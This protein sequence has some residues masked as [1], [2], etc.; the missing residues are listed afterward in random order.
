MKHDATQ[1]A[2]IPLLLLDFA[3][4]RG[5]DRGELMRAAGIDPDSLADPDQRL[6]VAKFRRLW[7]A[8]IERDDDPA[9]GLHVGETATAKRMGLVGYAIFFS[10]DLFEALMQMARYSRLVTDAVGIRLT[11]SDSAVV[12]RTTLRP[13][14]ISLQHPVV[15]ALSIL[16]TIAREITQ[17][18]FQPW[19]VRLPLSEPDNPDEYE[20]LFGPGVRFSADEAT[21]EFSAEQMML[22]V[23]ACDPS[24]RNYLNELADA[25][26]EELGRADVELIDEVRRGIWTSMQ[27]GRPSLQR[28]ATI[29]G[30]SPRTLQR[31]LGEQG[32]SYQA[33][34][35][36]LRRELSEELRA[37][38][39]Y[40]A[41][42]TAFLLGYSE[43]SAYQRAQ[44]RWRNMS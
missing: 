10:D 24:L 13:F 8:L 20:R 35:D 19:R 14:M 2:R 33:M 7:Q 11:P 3:E 31:R 1:I 21:I 17:S 22:P 23:V 28:T 44:R 25:K 18:D 9:L 40:S 12:L 39:G 15:S 30:M 6:P 42:E 32:S 5:L 37:G 41:S 29:L 36:E 34:L 43:P 4:S 27:Y 16:L 38:K 26:L